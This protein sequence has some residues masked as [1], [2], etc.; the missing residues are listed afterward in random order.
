[1]HEQGGKQKQD[2]N[3]PEWANRGCFLMYGRGKKT[4][5]G[6]RDDHGDQ[7]GPRGAIEG[8]QGV[9]S[10]REIHL[11][12]EKARKQTGRQN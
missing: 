10:P 8:E 12:N 2:K 4:R 1:M 11:G 9:R 7:R 5:E 3:I 6:D